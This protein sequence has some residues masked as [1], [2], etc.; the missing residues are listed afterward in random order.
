[1]DSLEDDRIS[2]LEV[3]IHEILQKIDSHQRLLIE[4]QT[5]LNERRQIT[6]TYVD[7]VLSKIEILKNIIREN[8][9]D[10]ELISHD[11]LRVEQIENQIK[12]TG[13]ISDSQ[14]KLLNDIYKQQKEFQKNK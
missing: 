13:K 1:M 2:S 11:M 3:Q 9:G 7:V 6:K 8:V 4:H 5:Q 10:D 14:F 12:T